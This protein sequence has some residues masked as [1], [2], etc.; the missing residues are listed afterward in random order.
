MA[1]FTGR[2]FEQTPKGGNFPDI[3][4]FVVNLSFSESLAFVSAPENSALSDN[5]AMEVDI[6]QTDT[7]IEAIIRQNCADQMTER[8][9]GGPFT[10]SDIRGCRL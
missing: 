8:F 7:E 4:I 3:V 5:A 1:K 6:S 9:I 10:T 2:I